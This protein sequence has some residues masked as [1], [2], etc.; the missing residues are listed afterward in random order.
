[1]YYIGY[2]IIISVSIFLSS[3]IDRHHNPQLERVSDLIESNPLVA[4]DSLE[5]INRATLDIENRHYYDFLLIKASDKAYIPH[6]SDSLI[7]S[8]VN[9]YSFDKDNPLYIES[10]YYAGRVYSDKGDKKTAFIY[11]Q[12][13]LDLLPE[14]T[15][16]PH[17]RSHVLSQTGRFLSDIRLYEKSL[18]IIRDVIKI[19]E[20]RGDSINLSFNHQLICDSF[21]HLEQYDSAEWH[22]KEAEKIATGFPTE[23]RASIR[24][25][26]AA[27]NLH[28]GNISTALS[29]IRH[30]PD[31]IWEEAR[32]FA[33]SYA[34]EI[35]LKG[36]ILDTAYIYSKELINS[37]D[38]L[39][40]KTG[41]KLL[42]LTPLEK[43]IPRDSLQFYYNKYRIALESYYNNREKEA[44]IIQYTQFNYDT[45]VQ[46]RNETE[47]DNVILKK[48][49][50]ALSVLSTV[51][52]IT[53]LILKFKIKMQQIM[54]FKVLLIIKDLK[55]SLA[56]HKSVIQK[57][58]S[59]SS[60]SAVNTAGS[61]PE[62]NT[63]ESNK[64][65]EKQHYNPNQETL[66]QPDNLLDIENQLMSTN[67]KQRNLL[68][69]IQDKL[70]SEMLALYV[71]GMLIPVPDRIKNSDE[72]SKLK[73]FIRLKQ[74]VDED[75]E[76][77][78][79]LKRCVSLA[80]PMFIERLNILTGGKLKTKDLQTAMLIKCGISHSQMSIIFGR[81][82]GTISQR[83]E[84]LS[85]KL[86]GNKVEMGILEQI[87]Q[88]L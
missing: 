54:L 18:P 87:I 42:L 72:Y 81:T 70:R 73:E 11:F 66:T 33:L 85:K 37:D 48:L 7:K 57:Y 68:N 29:L 30:S 80:A 24:V 76:F 63:S 43:L 10:L 74:A 36:N 51:A 15:P 12:K 41:Y 58:L 6:K 56:F 82:K 59:D 25:Y 50:V 4:I 88:I 45:H 2:L 79:D 31:S 47:Y 8:V 65:S 64:N 5:K 27:I 13:A 17:L 34:A 60:E 22:I 67:I 86:F 19:N 53:I 44:A 32:P 9:Y 21:I 71:P 83:K 23:H 78:L 52:G 35:Y 38:T 3:C 26:L 20:T 46:M 14:D 28:Q 69:D 75:S 39:N 1:M 40:Q 55:L 61:L 49:V 62:P 16:Y 77:W 84:T